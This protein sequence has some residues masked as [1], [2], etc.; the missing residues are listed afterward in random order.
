MKKAEKINILVFPCGSEIGLELH[1][2]L[3]RT[4]HFN[5]YGGSSVSDH[6][7]FVYEKYIGNIPDVSDRDFIT[8]I[9]DVIERF[10]IKY[11][12]PAHDSVVL[13]LSQEHAKGNLSCSVLT[14]DV[15]TCEISRSK[16]ATYNKLKD[17]IRVPKV[18]SH[19]RILNQSVYPVFLKPDVGQGSKGTYIANSKTEVDFYTNKDPN[20][21]I[22]EY[23]P[24][25]EYTVDCFTDKKGRLLF[26]QARERSRISNGISVRSETVNNSELSKIAQ[27]INKSLHFRG[28]WFFQVKVSSSGELTLMEIATR[29][30][31][32]MGVD[33]VMGANLALLTVYD[34]MN[35]EVDVL[36]NGHNMTVDRALYN[37]YT[38]EITYDH[39]YIDFDD[40][41]V[42]NG[43]VNPSIV[44]YLYQS[45]NKGIKIHLITKHKYDI[46]KTLKKYRLDS[47]FD[48]II[49]VPANA[50]KYQYINAEKSIFIDD[51]FAERKSVYYNLGIPVFDAHMIE[52]LVEGT[53]F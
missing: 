15:E 17:I 31:G 44:G 12:F 4:T 25:N 1:R 46:H 53:N 34:A 21:I 22:L 32:T 13:K 30:A 35:L 41:I 43:I 50:E 23:L 36:I 52:C 45:I 3:S 49:R 14:S 20:L 39:V 7:E 8:R 10:D 38:H 42:Q 18:Y 26:S 9:N 47:L 29:V 51:S 48:E 33:R 28:V 24:G 16:L 5:L 2:S 19:E 37:R 27:K 6:G 11:I 40:L